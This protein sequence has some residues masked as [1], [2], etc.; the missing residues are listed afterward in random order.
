MYYMTRLLLLVPPRN[1]NDTEYSVTRERLEQAGIQVTLTSVVEEEITG[2]GGMKITPEK[3]L[4]LTNPNNYDALVIIGGS[5]TPKLLDYPEVTN[6]IKKF[7][8]QGKPIAAICLA[9]I[10]LA[11]A[12]ILKGVI[13]TVFPTNF[14]LKWLK[15]GGATYSELNVV[16]DDNI[17]TADGPGAAKEFAGKILKKFNL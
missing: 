10:I 17:I 16:E 14:A 2:M 1:F 7:E 9:P 11:K 12:G 6:I 5:G 13:C 15:D 4:R 3:E 8:N